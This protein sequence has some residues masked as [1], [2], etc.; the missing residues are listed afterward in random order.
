[1]GGDRKK[2]RRLTVKA[3]YKQIQD[4]EAAKLINEE[5]LK[6]RAIEAAEQN[7]IVFIDEIDKVAK[8]QESGRRGCQPRRCAARPAAADR[9]LHGKH[10]ARN[11]PQRPYSFRRL[12]RLP[13]E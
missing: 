1:M 6:A 10:Q 5:E 9:R 7:G 4:E 3:A 2:T 12:R 13:P 11:D 8:R